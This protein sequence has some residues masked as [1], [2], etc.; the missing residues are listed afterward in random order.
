MTTLKP[1]ELPIWMQRSMRRTDWGMLLVLAFSLLAAWAFIF[2]PGLPRTN[3]SEHYVYQA[4]NVA[5]AL[6][7]GRLY[8]RWSADALNGYGAPIPQF[9]PPGAAYTAGLITYF[10]TGDATAAVKLV[11]VGALF[12]A[13]AATYAF[14]TRRSGAAAGVVAALLYVYS[15]YV[16]LTAPHLLGDLPGVVCAA[17]IPAL[18]WS[19]DR[20]LREN[21]PFDFACVSLLS[22]ALVLTEPRTA[23]AGWLLGLLLLLYSR[24]Q[25]AAFY[26]TLG[27][28]ALGAGLGACY[29]LPAFV[30]AGSVRWFA[31]PLFNPH[32]L[33]LP[34]LLLPQTRTDPAALLPAPQF[35]L[36][37]T[38]LLFSLASASMA[39]RRFGFHRLFLLIALVFI[40][41]ALSVFRTEVWLLAII[42]LCLSI[43]GSAV[44]FWKPTRLWLPILCG[45]IVGSSANVWLTPSWSET[46]LDTSPLAQ[47]EYEQRGFGIAT[48]TDGSPLPSSIDPDT[49]A[50]AALL[51]SYRAD[52]VNKVEQSA[53]AQ[54]GLLEH[55]THEER[56]QMRTFAPFTLRVLTASFPG[57]SASLNGAPL[58]L[59]TDEQGLLQVSLP[60]D[61]AGELLITLDTTPTR[62]TAWVISWGALA[63]LLGIT[64]RR[65]RRAT[66][67]HYDPP[68]LL[69]T[70]QARLVAVLVVGFGAALALVALP[71]APLKAEFRAETAPLQAPQVSGGNGSAL[72]LLNYELDRTRLTAGENFEI[73]LYWQTSSTPD[74]N[75]QVRVSLLNL[76][77]GA[78]TL[79]TAQRDPGGFPTLRWLP[80]RY[81]E[82]I[83]RIATP[84][85]MPTG[86][87]SPSIEVCPAECFPATQLDFFGDDG[88]TYGSVLV[89]PV[90]LTVEPP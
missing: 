17:L 55:E 66:S 1:E 29:W 5:R 41:L 63:I 30:E 78:Y 3:E 27:A 83:Y 26:R 82:D 37:L 8:P 69:E 45:V 77:T 49:P 57:W 84:A 61:L 18:L 25:P 20:L 67:D 51:A 52:G 6:S 28:A 58:P 2:Q 65:T 24:P 36:G 22:A 54:I 70:A 73:A 11:F 42:C 40:V 56:F 38:L 16:G 14:V 48:L 80:Q 74:E 60:A 46:S 10:V 88:N 23:L 15:P 53:N 47:L 35:T 90:I 34:E 81:V 33:R 32:M 44:V 75:Y 50:N 62:T 31:R 85:E 4:A 89:L 7:E 21:T 9:Y 72:N 64:I 79:R 59:E 76:N 12:G 86:D 43:G 68:R 39:V 71:N 13:G 87:Y 19:I